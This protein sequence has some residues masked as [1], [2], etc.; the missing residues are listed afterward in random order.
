VALQYCTLIKANELADMVMTEERFLFDPATEALERALAVQGAERWLLVEQALH[1][2]RLAAAMK[3]SE[4]SLTGLSAVAPPENIDQEVSIFGEV[5]QA[6][7]DAAD[8]EAEADI[9]AGRLI[10]HEAMR[11]WLVSWGTAD[12]LPPPQVGD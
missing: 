10:S 5:D 12:E 2:H 9:A 3:V 6:F 8:A 1:L 4:A 11:R 7:E